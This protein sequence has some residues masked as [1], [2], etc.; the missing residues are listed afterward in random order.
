MPS[1]K[2]LEGLV[3]RYIQL[4]TEQCMVYEKSEIDLIEEEAVVR[5]ITCKCVCVC[6]SVVIIQQL[7]G[8]FRFGVLLQVSACL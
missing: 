2:Y 7:T 4:C 1:C 3:A 8:C 6:V 5:I